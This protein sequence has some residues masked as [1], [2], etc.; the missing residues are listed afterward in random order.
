MAAPAVKLLCVIAGLFLVVV[1]GWGVSFSAL[2]H[3][4][5]G[6]MEGVWPTPT[7]PEKFS[8]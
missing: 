2:G 1:S 5:A 3:C 7:I 6:N 8:L 4:R